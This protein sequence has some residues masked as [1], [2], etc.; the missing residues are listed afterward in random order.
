MSQNLQIEYVQRLIKIAGIGKKSKYDNLAKTSALYQL[1]TITQQ[2]TSW[3]ADEATK[4]HKAYLD[5]IIK[6][7]LEA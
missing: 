4:A 1:H 5:L 3:G 2:D 7:A 6:K